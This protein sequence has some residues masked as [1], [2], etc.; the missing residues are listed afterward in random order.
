MRF[1]SSAW[2]DVG[3]HVLFICELD[4]SRRG[5]DLWGQ[6]PP[7]PLSGIPKLHK[8]GE[9]RCACTRMSHVLVVYIYI[10]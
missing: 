3:L 9:K 1:P 2:Q 7:T 4:G 8:R 5:W 6:D 10:R